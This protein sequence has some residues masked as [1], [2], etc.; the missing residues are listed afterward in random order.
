[1]KSGHPAA[2]PAF[3][4]HLQTVRHAREQVDQAI[5]ALDQARGHANHAVKLIGE[6]MFDHLCEEKRAELTLPKLNHAS[7]IT[8]RLAESIQKLSSLETAARAEAKEYARTVLIKSGLP[9][10]LREELEKELQLME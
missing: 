6:Y 8:R 1:M 2:K 7:G 5:S 3:T 10:D 9:P 4:R